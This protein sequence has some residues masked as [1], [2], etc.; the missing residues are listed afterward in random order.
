MEP[1]PF[2]VIGLSLL[3]TNPRR[4]DGVELALVQPVV[5][6]PPGAFGRVRVNFRPLVVPELL[7]GRDK[8]ELV[9]LLLEVVRVKFKSE[10]SSD[11]DIV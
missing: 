7:L 2:A 6:L 8:V 1:L 3:S 10:L 9:T 5:D 4:I 11:I